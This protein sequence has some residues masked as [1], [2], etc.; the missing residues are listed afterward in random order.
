M[1]KTPQ[2]ILKML[3]VLTLMLCTYSATIA[4]T[5]SED[6]Q[7]RFSV[8]NVTDRVAAKVVQHDLMQDPD[9]YNCVFI[10]GCDCFK[11]ST[12][13][14]LDRESLSELLEDIG[15]ELTGTMYCPD[16]RVLYAPVQEFQVK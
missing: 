14:T 13:L 12:P 9:V 10:V 15:Y 16:G 3:A 1:L 2:A 11:I 6:I 5:P 8:L 7:Y 4:Q